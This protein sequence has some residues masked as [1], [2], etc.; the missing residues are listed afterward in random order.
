M[1]KH[2]NMQRDVLVTNLEEQL[3]ELAREK[4]GK[5]LKECTDH[6]T[7]YVLLEMTTRLMDVAEVSN[8]EKKIYYISME[9]LIGKLLS[10]NLINLRVYDRV[11]EILEK[12]GKTLAAVEEC[13]PEPS[14]GNGGLGRLAACFLDSI[15]TLGLAGEG[16][17][18]NYHFGLF[19]QVFKD[20]LQSAEKNDWI[21]EQSWLEKTDTTFEVSFGKKK[22]VSRLYNMN[23][24]GY[25]TGV[26]KLRLFDIESVDESLVKEGIDFDKTKI[27]KNLTLF[28][29][30]DDSDEAGN[31]LRI[32][33]EYFLVS[34]AA[35]LILR[36]Q[37]ERQYDLHEL[38][39]HAVIQI[40]DTHPTMIIPELIRILVE[41][42]AFN[43]D[44]AIDVVSKTCAYTNHTILAEALETWPLK[45]LEKVV[46]QL[47]PYI[48]EL[49]KRIKAKYKNPKVQI[50][51]KDK[52]VHMAFIDIHYGFSING[53]AAIHTDILKD[54]ELNDFYKIYPEKFN[55]K[56]NGITFRRWLLSCNH[57]LADFLS[58]TIGDGFKKDAMKLEKLLEHIDEQE[59]L[60]RLE[61]IKKGKKQELVA[62][63][64][65]HENVEVDPDSIFDIQ[66]KRLHEYKRQQMNAL[67]I[68]HK[69]LEIKGG[70][71]PTRPLTFIFGAKAAPAYVIAK[72]IIHLILVLQEI[73]NNDPDVNKYM[74]VVMVENY[75]V[76]YAERL[77]PACDVSEQISLASKEASGTSNMK[78]MLNGAVTL[79][80]DDGANVEI[81]ELVGD[82]NIYIF[83]VSADEVIEHYKK[84]DYVSKD[85]Y[86]K[87][88]V[89][90]EAVDFIVSKQ[91]L[92]VGHKENLERLHKELL[93]KD[94][95]M[96]LIDLES[97]IA[98]K[99]EIFA[100][101]EKRDKWKRMMLTN[102]AK[103][104]FFSSD[105][106]IEEYNRD[107]WHL[108]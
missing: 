26:N 96:T 3:E 71:K 34:N 93:N 30:P 56:T 65:E 58:Q 106:T 108:N 21:E 38:H 64:K 48:K 83:G 73:V 17:G 41:E 79:G 5:S 54:S 39:N 24:V 52:K 28:L 11:K 31:L 85:Y 12:N 88:K 47:V 101:Y 18:L 103:A 95:F 13:E 45:Y 19:K 50:I 16:I 104:G 35:Q 77:I 91:C 9:F 42:K 49:D 90:K 25:D 29:Y 46:P 6:E 99:D 22:V 44:D 70:K 69:Y 68:I 27:D 23:V 76:S 8:G 37:K 53:V 62:Y 43:I 4:F 74:K 82:D 59:T 97:Y 55:N 107:I 51:D 36:E 75:N 100:D 32:Y 86:K 84:A 66:V 10:N 63:L 105:R 1:S 72:D 2:T 87:S 67:Y 92:K 98:K 14:L 33:Q 78:F 57:P 61:E 81:H 40:N 80:T 7:Y 94:W 15:A 60:D 102:I 89:I 20:H